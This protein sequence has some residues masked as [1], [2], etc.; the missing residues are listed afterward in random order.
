MEERSIEGGQVKGVPEFWVSE[1]TVCLLGADGRLVKVRAL[2]V[3][4]STPT[5]TVLSICPV[6]EMN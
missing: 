4:E 5:G 2:V 6:E 1:C 3:G